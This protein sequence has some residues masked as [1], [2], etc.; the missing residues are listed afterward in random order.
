MLGGFA[1]GLSDE[2]RAALYDPAHVM[3]FANLEDGK[4][5][6]KAHGIKGARA[7]RVRSP[8]VQPVPRASAL[9]VERVDASR[10]ARST[11]VSRY[12]TQR[13]TVG[14]IQ[15]GIIRIPSPAKVMFPGKRAYVEIELRGE[16]KSC[17]WDPRYGS[18]QERSGVLGIGT[19]L[20]RR[21][22]TEDEQLHIRLERDVRYLD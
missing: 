15:R 4:G 12:Q 22:V 18:D 7:P 13:I 1:E 19:A 11:A 3:P 16:R 20:M 5:G 14:D 9:A 8:R 17:R 10:A 21:L 6:R 2:A